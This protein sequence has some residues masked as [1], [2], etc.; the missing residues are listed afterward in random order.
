MLM[1]FEGTTVHQPL[2][3][4]QRGMITENELSRRLWNNLVKYGMSLNTSLFVY[5]CGDGIP[6]EVDQ[7]NVPT[8]TEA[9]HVV[10]HPI[11][12]IADKI[13]EGL[14]LPNGFSVNRIN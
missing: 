5:K 12:E 9:K 14:I 3:K 4:K 10:R 6:L 13:G 7:V 1:T 8:T 11:S 2:Q